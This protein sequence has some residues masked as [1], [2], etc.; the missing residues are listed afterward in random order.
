MY[1]MVF[2][3]RGGGQLSPKEYK[4]GTIENCVNTGVGGGV[5]RILLYHIV[6]MG[7]GRGSVFGKRIQ[8]G[9]YAH[10]PNSC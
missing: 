5:R 2:R 10:F 6:F 8:W 9:V 1:D 3:G 7:R 4:G